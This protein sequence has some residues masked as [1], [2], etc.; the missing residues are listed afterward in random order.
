MF[1]RP[2]RFTRGGLV[3]LLLLAGCQGPFD[4]REGEESLQHYV[5]AALDRE[6]Q[7]M[8]SETLPQTATARPSPVEEA[9]AER[10]EELDGIGPA[11]SGDL[12]PDLGTD[13]A[14]GSQ[15]QVTVALGD[16]VASAVRN[17]LGVQ[18][19]SLQPSITSEDVIAAEAAFD[20]LLSAEAGFTKVDE[21]QTV[22]VLGGIRL[23]SPAQGAETYNFETGVRKRFQSGGTLS[24]STDLARSRNRSSGIGLDPD[25]AYSAGLRIGL[26]QP[27]LRGFG[28]DVNTASIRLAEHARDRSVEQLRLDLLEAVGDTESAYWALVYAWENLAIKQWLVSVGEEVRI[29]MEGRMTFDTTTAQ[30][31]DAVATVEQRKADVIRAERA[32]RG[33]SDSLK[34]LVN[35]PALTVGSEALLSPADVLAAEPITFSLREAIIEA[36]ANRPEIRQAALGI[37][38]AG[39]AQMLADNNRL[40]MLNATAQMAYFGLDSSVG[41]AYDEIG[42]GS[43]IDY[44]LGLAFEYPIG[45][46]RAEAE[47]RRS[48][49]ERTAAAIAYRRAVQ[50]VVLDVKSALRD[51]MANYELIQATRSYRVAQ[52]ENLRAL[53]VEEETLAALTPEFLNLKFSRQNG[54]AGARA[55]ELLA[56]TNYRQSLA[57]LYR[58]MGTSLTM[59]G[60]ELETVDAPETLLADDVPH[61]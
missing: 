44:I 55:Q 61:P 54:L 18:A 60:I 26:D 37:E 9:L 5:D 41:D 34:A 28:R 33:A 2:E 12:P 53:A 15:Q 48:R 32:L 11:L 3:A 13:L 17:N 58:A 19:S 23:G 30:F 31:A 42:E 46:R 39:I 6:I 47:Y 57:N 16:V 51:V 35:D 10:R 43:F 50:N 52:A 8:P 14:G 7:A 59:Q 22:P 20:W 4:G 40:P 21:P 49:L 45:N 29:K 24:V 36:M 25:P 38:D 1:T 56:L 27:L